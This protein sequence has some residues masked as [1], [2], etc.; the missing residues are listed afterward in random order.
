[1]ISKIFLGKFWHWLL[2]A[3][4]TTMLWYAG[5]QRAHV[6]EFNLFIIAM[7]LGTIAG[8]FCIIRFSNPGE[9]VTREPIVDDSGD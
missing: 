5:T 7:L 2:L 9:Q 1:M 4:A 8:L 6:I 3:L